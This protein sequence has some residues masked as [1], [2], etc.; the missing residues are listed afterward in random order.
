VEHNITAEVMNPIINL[1]KCENGHMLANSNNILNRL[2]TCVPAMNVRETN[3]L[4][5]TGIHMARPL[6]LERKLLLKNENYKSP[7]FV[8]I[9]TEL[10]E[11][12][13]K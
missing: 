10:V 11:A 9:P 3:D 1:I 7:A 4:R 13:D 2:K 6:V 12:R 5:Q 8:Q